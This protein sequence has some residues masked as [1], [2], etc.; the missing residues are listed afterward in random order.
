MFSSACPREEILSCKLPAIDCSV[1]VQGNVMVRVPDNFEFTDVTTLQKRPPACVVK[2]A[3]SLMRKMRKQVDDEA[4]ID[5]EVDDVNV[6]VSIGKLGVFSRAGLGQLEWLAEVAEMQYNSQEEETWLTQTPDNLDNETRDKIS[7]LLFKFPLNHLVA[8]E[9]KHSVSVRAFSKLALERYIDDTVI[10]TAIA[11]MKRQCSTNE[12]FLCLPA[13]TITWLNTGDRGFIRQCFQEVLL[14]VKPGLLSL[15]LVPVNMD[16]V[17]W[18]L[19]VVDVKNKEVYFDDGL[20]WSFSKTSYAHLIIREL[21]F[22]FPECVN[23][24]LDHWRNVKTFKRF[25]MPRQPTDGQVIGSGSCGVGVILS[26]LDFM[27]SVEPQ[28]VSPSWNFNEMTVHRKDIMKLL[29][30]T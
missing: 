14:N 24:S 21:H 22:K 20:G 3:V 26:A 27:T 4:F 15:V 17:H 10:D 29:T 28:S 23:L 16:D 8:K 30:S 6:G 11:R 13:H 9:G 25:G 1:T 7:N 12:S 2:D 5:L 18:G 19:M